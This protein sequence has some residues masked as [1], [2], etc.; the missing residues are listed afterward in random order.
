M[1]RTT[2]KII[3]SDGDVLHIDVST[4]ANPNAVMLI[5]D[6]Y[7]TTIVMS[8]EYGRW[9]AVKCGRNTYAQSNR[10]GGCGS[11]QIHKLIM[12][13]DCIDHINRNGLDN[14][15]CNL[16]RCTKGQNGI[17]AD[18]KS[19]NTSGVT[20]VWWHKEIKR[21][22]ADIKVNRKKICLGSFIEKDDAVKARKEA[23]K[24]YFGE[25]A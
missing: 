22:R 16:R 17:N 5:D 4:D 25:F 12:T 20:G 7:W 19:S 9:Y 10:R 15:I 24:K 13:A 11:I 18:P 8:G 21:W 23:E 1:R 3:K 6:Y 14:R 2:N